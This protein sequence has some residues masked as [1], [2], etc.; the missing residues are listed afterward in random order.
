MPDFSLNPFSFQKTQTFVDSRCVNI[1]SRSTN[2]TGVIS[3]EFS[4]LENKP[5]FLTLQDPEYVYQNEARKGK[6]LKLWADYYSQPENRRE[7]YAIMKYSVLPVL[8]ENLQ[9]ENIFNLYVAQPYSPDTEATKE[10]YIKSGGNIEIRGYPMV[11]PHGLGTGYNLPKVISE[12][13]VRLLVYD[14]QWDG[15]IKDKSRSEEQALV[16]VDISPLDLIQLPGLIRNLGKLGLRGIFK[17]ASKSRAMVSFAVPKISRQASAIAFKASKKLPQIFRVRAEKLL[18]KYELEFKN[19]GKIE[20]N[21]G[22]VLKGD[23]AIKSLFKNKLSDISG[24]S[25]HWPEELAAQHRN[26]IESFILS[27]I[28]DAK[29]RDQFVAALK[30]RSLK[31]DLL[32]KLPEDTN[33]ALGKLVEARWKTLRESF[34]TKIYDDKSLIDE[35]SKINIR[36]AKRGNAPTLSLWGKK[37]KLNLDHNARKIDDPMFAFS[38]ENMRIL[39]PLDNSVL[40]ESLVKDFRDLTGQLNMSSE[41]F[42]SLVEKELPYDFRA[43]LKSVLDTLPFEDPNFRLDIPFFNSEIPKATIW[44]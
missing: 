43:G 2:N 25:K 33:K 44:K 31:P 3:N 39:T 40:K 10:D 24:I 15:R 14:L 13:S 32:N 23:E 18:S 29:L 22:K 1:E 20:V 41:E 19:L 5:N 37:I 9:A 16:P 12:A 38:K 4:E 34:W 21:L 26:E 17:V 8:V 30:N 6:L 28:R 35:L 7:L 11:P 42:L 36:I 27:N